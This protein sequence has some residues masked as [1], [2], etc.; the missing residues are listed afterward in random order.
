MRHE[1]QKTI[2]RQKNGWELLAEVERIKWTDEEAGKWRGAGE[3]EVSYEQ[4]APGPY[5]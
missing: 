4:D 3:N 1:G 5:S 2:E